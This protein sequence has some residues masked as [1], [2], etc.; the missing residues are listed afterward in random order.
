MRSFG[1][2]GTDSNNPRIG[3]TI[4]DDMNDDLE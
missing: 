4:N 3:G 1:E 2:K